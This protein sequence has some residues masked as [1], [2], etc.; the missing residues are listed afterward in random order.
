MT[1]S[2]RAPLWLSPL[3]LVLAFTTCSSSAATATAATTTSS[4]TNPPDPREA[5]CLPESKTGRPVVE[6]NRRRRRR[7]R[8]RHDSGRRHRPTI[9][10]NGRIQ[11]SLNDDGE[12]ISATC[13]Q[14]SNGGNNWW[15]AEKA[16]TR[17]TVSSTKNA[18]RWHLSGFLPVGFV[19]SLAVPLGQRR[20]R[21]CSS[22]HA[23]RSL[24]GSKEAR[25]WQGAGGRRTARSGRRQRHFLPWEGRRRSSD[26]VVVDGGTGD[27]EFYSW[28]ETDS[29][30]EV[31]VALPP[32]TAAKSVQLSVTKT[33]LT[34]GLKGREG[35]VL[36]GSLKGKVLAD[37]SHWTME[38]MEDTGEKVLYLCLEKA[39]DMEALAENSMPGDW[40]GVLEGEEPLN[41]YYPDKDK[42]FDVDAYVKKMGYDRDRDIGKV[43]KAMFSNLT[44]EMKQNL[45]TTLPK[46]AFTDKDDM[47]PVMAE[48]KVSPIIDTGVLGLPP[49]PPLEP[50]IVTEV[51]VNVNADGTVD[52]GTVV[53]AEVMREESW[54]AGFAPDL[55]GATA[56][57]DSGS[58][59]YSPA[60]FR[61]GADFNV[62]VKEGGGTRE[63]TERQREVSAGLRDTYEKLVKRG[64]IKDTNSDGTPAKVPDM[65]E[66]ARSYETEGFMF[67]DGDF[68]EEELSKYMDMDM[69]MGMDADLPGGDIDLSDPAVRSAFGLE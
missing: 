9:E 58:G 14:R 49:P 21:T 17:E 1:A 36:K 39:V 6:S 59:G 66:M 3:V 20:E 64:M 22:S 23:V 62:P 4:A 16:T 34:L 8:G 42:D 10:N 33:A 57:D 46:S 55:G 31:R 44:E 41:L 27:T 51:A 45:E 61:A 30:I 37:E 13:E 12:K 5:S 40:E 43:D 69:G 11:S 50:E 19:P 24:S 67:K 15:W 32:G 65:D 29:D 35:P 54:A 26:V 2:A 18:R 60:G 56:G 38:E 53:D 28:T 7:R 68:S 25:S 63:L 48:P 52:D 47:I